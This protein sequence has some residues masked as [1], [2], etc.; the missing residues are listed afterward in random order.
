MVSNCV[1]MSRLRSI[2]I[3]L[4]GLNAALLATAGSG[5]VYF[6][7]TS[8]IAFQKLASLTTEPLAEP[9]WSEARHPLDISALIA[10][11]PYSG[12]EGIAAVLPSEMYERTLLDGGGNCANKSRGLAYYLEQR[13][14]PF[15][16]VELLKADGFLVGQG[17][18]VVRA[19]V[20]HQGEARV[21]LID[22]LEGGLPV[23]SGTTMDLP[24]LLAADPFTIEIL[25]LNW[26]MDRYSEYY[27]GFLDDVIV[28]RVS[29]DEIVSFFRF[30]EGAYVPLGLDRFERVVFNALAI[31]RG[32]FPSLHVSQ[33]DYDRLTEAHRGKLAL[34]L[35]MVEATRLLLW[36]LPAAALW[37]IARSISKRVA[38][39]RGAATPSPSQA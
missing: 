36:S 39:A 21:A 18:V 32:R 13:G 35:S 17:H 37:I 30:L 38:R 24:D 29:D 7:A 19:L 28:A 27:G 22:M 14:L 5:A 2:T 20:M 33:A 16:R 34:A 26:R 6:A 25:P 31:V 1:P 11:I 23:C 12:S 10:S 15:E 4:V 9:E 8:P 3:F